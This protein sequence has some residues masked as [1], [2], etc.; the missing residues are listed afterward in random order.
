MLMMHIRDALYSASVRDGQ[1]RALRMLRAVSRSD[2]AADHLAAMLDEYDE[3][4]ADIEAGTE[5]VCELAAPCP[6]CALI[7]RLVE[8]S[9]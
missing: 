6:V 8:G 3:A 4:V 9:T 7:E 1:A 5:R 2:H